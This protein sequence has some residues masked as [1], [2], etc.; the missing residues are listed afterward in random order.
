MKVIKRQK[1]SRNCIICGLDN[2]ASVKAPFY[3][4]EDKCLVT[5]FE[6]KDFHQSYPE[7]VHGGMISAM[8]D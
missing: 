3:E 8:L 4:M 5:I 1:N 2:D 7:R 6:F